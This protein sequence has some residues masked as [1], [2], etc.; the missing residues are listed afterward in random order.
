MVAPDSTSITTLLTGAVLTTCA[1]LGL[2][3]CDGTADTSELPTKPQF[4]HKDGHGGGPGGGGGGG[5]DGSVGATF[6]SLG[7]DSNGDGLGDALATPSAQ[8]MELEEEGG[9]LRLSTPRKGNETTDPT[10]VT[11]DFDDTRAA[12][13]AAFS[14]ESFEGD[15]CSI[16]R[17]T[18]SKRR[19]IAP[20]RIRT[21]IEKLND[22]EQAR[23][24]FVL[25][26]DKNA[27]GGSSEDHRLKSNWEEDGEALWNLGVGGPGWASSTVALLAGDIDGDATVQFT[28]G[29]VK[30]KDRTEKPTFSVR[31]P[32]H[33][34]DGVEAVIDRP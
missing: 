20:G 7:A 33:P 8:A 13:L 31:C 23:L 24:M 2:A 18:G 25:E 9:V 12:A 16:A 28:G 29:G 27:L 4:H 32:I 14:D 21:A 11:H 15:D 10:I 22:P 5:E 19:P 3:A 30:V 34:D 17:D 1:S 26:L 6:L